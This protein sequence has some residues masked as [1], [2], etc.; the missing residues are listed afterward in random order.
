V[1]DSFYCTRCARDEPERIERSPFPNPLGERIAREICRDCWEE[2]KQHQ[3]LLINH[4]GLRLNEAP[5][6]EFL[7]T[8]LRSFLFG[9]GEPAADIDPEQQGS[10]TW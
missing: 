2:W 9:E 3:L 5:A 7:Y 4:F 8:N 6:R 10:V 1:S